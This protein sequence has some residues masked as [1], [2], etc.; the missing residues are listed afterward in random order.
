VE[1]CNRVAFRTVPTTTAG[2]VALIGYAIE[3]VCTHGGGALLGDDAAWELLGDE[4]K[5]TGNST[6]DLFQSL[7][8]FL[9]EV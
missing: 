6:I 5:P 8:E 7:T 1:G 2:A 4:S 9:R 3:V